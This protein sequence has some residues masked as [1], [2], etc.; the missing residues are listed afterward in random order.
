MCRPVNI[1]TKD[2]L[3]LSY[4]HLPS[5]IAKLRYAESDL[6]E[7]GRKIEAYDYYMLRRDAE[8]RFKKIK[9]RLCKQ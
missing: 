2:I 9:Y 4:K 6:L 8:I 3:I 7:K 1:I 5:L